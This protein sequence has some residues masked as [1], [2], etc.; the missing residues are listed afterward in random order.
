MVDLTQF[1]T[2]AG[3]AVLIA[4]ILTVFCPPGG[5]KLTETRVP[6]IAVILGILL[7]VAIGYSTEAL[8]SPRHLTAWVIGGILAGLTAIGYSQA[9]R[10]GRRNG[11]EAKNGGGNSNQNDRPKPVS[12]G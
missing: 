6:Y 2:V 10:F 12:D 8:T 4:V 9:S 11:G 3:L 1:A 5:G 7:S